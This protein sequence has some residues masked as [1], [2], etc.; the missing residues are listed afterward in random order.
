M[1]STISSLVPGSRLVIQTSKPK[2][3][4]M[5]S[6][7]NVEHFREMC[8]L[9]GQAIDW[10]EWVASPLIGSEQYYYFVAQNFI[11]PAEVRR[12]GVIVEDAP[13]NPDI[14]AMS[15]V[16]PDRPVFALMAKRVETRQEAKR[17]AEEEAKRVAEEEAALRAAEEAR[18]AADDATTSTHTVPEAG[19][20]SRTAERED[21]EHGEDEGEEVREVENPSGLSEVDRA[22]I[23]AEETRAA[24][25]EAIRRAQEAAA[26]VAQEEAKTRADSGAEVKEVATG[27][28][29]STT[30][31]Q[32]SSSS[33]TLFSDQNYF[34]SPTPQMGGQSNL[35]TGGYSPAPL[36]PVRAHFTGHRGVS[37]SSGTSTSSL[38]SQVGRRTFSIEECGRALKIFGAQSGASGAAGTNRY[39]VVSSGTLE[40]VHIHVKRADLWNWMVE[41]LEK[42]GGPGP[43]TYLV[44][45]ERKYDVLGLFKAILKAATV[46][47][48][49]AYQKKMEEFINAVPMKGEDFFLFATRLDTLASAIEVDTELAP[50]F[51]KGLKE[52]LLVPKLISSI[53]KFGTRYKTYE[54]Q[55][56]VFDTNAWSSLTARDLMT[57]MKQVRDNT[58][59]GAEAGE[60]GAVVMHTSSGPKR[61][62]SYNK[63]GGSE[64]KGDGDKG[65]QPRGRSRSRARSASRPRMRS[66]S[67]SK[68]GV[69]DCPRNACWDF[70]EGKKCK[71]EESGKKCPFKHVKKGSV[72]QPAPQKCNKC[73][74]DHQRDEC[75]FT[76]A[77][78]HCGKDGHKVTV[79]RIKLAKQKEPSKNKKQVHLAVG[80]D[81][82][83]GRECRGEFQG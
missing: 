27:T 80:E 45:R 76:G 39:W 21:G 6:F 43:Y 40:S 7:L 20:E 55:L 75:S 34:Q 10:P 14:R 37:T 42:S 49:F 5:H 64:R 24:A 82:E 15:S 12:A 56:A 62:Q 71:T 13:R 48:P 72:P 73:G 79:C 46:T 53:K 66:K 4:R 19:G 77:C 52:W 57:Q 50:N 1:T 30:S 70:W 3:V 58:E 38:P 16:L 32:T 65:E 22:R 17:A 81:A 60:S 31:V 9:Y 83:D 67:A 41:C 23:F 44:G 78:A 28:S 61:V 47:T 63:S 59:Q 35:M 36:Q 74:G 11:D 25:E 8:I 26:V 69:S 68:R 33:H 54:D 51:P 29:S 2:V 18:R